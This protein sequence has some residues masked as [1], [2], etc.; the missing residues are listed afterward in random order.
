MQAAMLA[1]AAASSRRPLVAVDVGCGDGT[2]TA[3]AIGPLQTDP[4]S[5]GQR[6]RPRLVV[7]R[8]RSRPPARRPRGPGRDKRP[9]PSAC[10]WQCGCGHHERADR[11]PRGYRRRARRKQDECSF[12]AGDCCCR[13]PIWRPGTTVCS[14][15]SE[16]SRCSPRSACVASTAARVAMWSGTCASSPGVR[17]SSCSLRPD[18][19]RSTSQAPPTTTSPVRCVRWIALLCRTP[20]LSSI[21][22]ASARRAT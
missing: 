20:G 5:R 9:G 4:G 19:S 21:L 16:C 14:S 8:P 6:H 10:F 11:A 17:S 1:E 12:L 13:R 7:R 18:S 15:R 3:V 22:L 2:A